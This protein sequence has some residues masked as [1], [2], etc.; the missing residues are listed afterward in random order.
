MEERLCVSLDI[1]ELAEDP[2][3]AMAFEEADGADFDRDAFAGLVDQDDRAVDVFVADHVLG[4][5]FPGSPGLLGRDDG[6]H[7][8]ATHV[9]D[10][11]P[12][13]RIEPP[14]DLVFVDDVA[15]DIHPLE[16]V[17]NITADPFQA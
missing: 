6:R 8:T 9:S 10:Q 15:R 17:R 5:G 7:L 3:D 4:E 1:R 11:P 14:D 16:G 2:D 13:G 12:G